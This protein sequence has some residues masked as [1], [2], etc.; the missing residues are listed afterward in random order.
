MLSLAFSPPTLHTLRLTGPLQRRVVAAL[1]PAVLLAV[2]RSVHQFEVLQS[3]VGALAVDVVDRFVAGE[4]ATHRLFHDQTVLTDVAPTTDMDEHISTLG[5]AP[6]APRPAPV[7]MAG[8]E[9]PRSTVADRRLLTTVA[10]T[11]LGLGMA[12]GCMAFQKTLAVLVAKV[13]APL[14][15]FPT[16]ALAERRLETMAAQ[17][18]G[19]AI[20]EQVLV[21]NG[22]LAAA[23]T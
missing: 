23:R 3:V 17:Q 18:E 4:F 9:P 7:V 14:N 22:L 5:V 13:R 12:A 6:L 8:N 1:R 15:A 20:S 2:L 16:A 19:R 10:L 21:R 11:E